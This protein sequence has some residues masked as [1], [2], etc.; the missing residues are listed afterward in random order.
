V[1]PRKR[2]EAPSLPFM[3]PVRVVPQ[4]SLYLTGRC[5]CGTKIVIHRE[6]LC[7]SC[8]S[9]RQTVSSLLWAS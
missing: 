2:S 4:K 3:E 5:V 1:S 6:V 8:P 7:V 9:C